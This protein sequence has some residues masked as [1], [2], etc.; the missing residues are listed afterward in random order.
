MNYYKENIEEYIDKTKNIDMKKEYDTFL[1]YVK[2]EGKILDVGFGSGR[3][4]FYFAKKKYQVL[5]IDTC[6]EFCEKAQDKGIFEVSHQSVLDISYKEEFDGVWASASIL[7]L[8]KNEL[9]QALDKCCFAL[10]KGG[11]MYASFKKG[12][13]EGIRDGRYYTDLEEKTA[14]EFIGKTDFEIISIWV[15]KDK[16]EREQEWL[17]VLLRRPIASC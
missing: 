9:L 7:H 11:V 15:S 4:S 13:F 8:S 17:N 3:D 16:Q 6:K 14:C 1:Q 5:A 10:K 12:D 2:Q